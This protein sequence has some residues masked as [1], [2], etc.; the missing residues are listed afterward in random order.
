MQIIYNRMNRWADKNCGTTSEN[1]VHGRKPGSE[2]SF[3]H[4]SILKRF[5]LLKNH[6]EVEST[7]RHVSFVQIYL[8]AFERM[9]F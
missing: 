2:P 8:F 5:V 9:M 4:K 3:R 1:I 7:F 6:L